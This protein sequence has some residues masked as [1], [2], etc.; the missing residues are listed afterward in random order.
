[1]LRSRFLGSGGSRNCASRVA[2]YEDLSP[3][4]TF[5]APSHSCDPIIPG[6]TIT[7]VRRAE[8]LDSV[9]ENIE[10]MTRVNNNRI[11]M[12]LEIATCPYSEM[13]LPPKVAEIVRK[14][15]RG[16]PTI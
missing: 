10:Q 12:L 7:G 9:S 6:I 15:K 5:P 3:Q 16:P 14:N 11:E 8:E 1:M 2:V 13:R 4:I